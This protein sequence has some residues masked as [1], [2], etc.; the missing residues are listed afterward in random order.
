MKRNSALLTI[1]AGFLLL[2]PVLAGA[3]SGSPILIRPSSQ[4]FDEAYK[5][6]GRPGPRINLTQAQAFQRLSGH[7]KLGDRAVVSGRGALTAGAFARRRDSFIAA[8]RK[9]SATLTPADA[10]TGSGD[11]N[12]IEPN[13]TVAQSVALPVNVAGTINPSGD[14]DFFAFQ[15]F[16]GQQIT[17]ESFA[18]RIPGSNLIADIVLMDSAGNL[19]DEEQG[20]GVNDPFIQLQAPSTDILIAGITDLDGLGGS[21]FVYLLSMQAGVDVQEVEPNNTPTSP[22]AVPALPVTVFG[23]ITSNTDADFYQFFGTAGETLIA[24]VDAAV[25]GSSLVSEINLT[26]PATGVVYFY[27]NHLDGDDPR[28]NIVLPYTGNYM[29]GL[30]ALGAATSGFY[31]LNLS[32]VPGAGAPTVTGVTVLGPKTMK[33]SGAGFSPSPIVSL[34]ALD[35][36]TVKVSK[37]LLKAHGK[38]A[39]GKVVTV[40]IGPDGRRSNPLIIQ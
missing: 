36:P 30:D 12:E 5:A 3:Q 27:N 4:V 22:N 6:V 29:I 7:T 28:F 34:N 17:V 37:G 19:L 10:G 39:A 33:V 40:S 13:D 35:R 11:I 8:A 15:A 16:A 2:A 24:D 21:S 18:S 26:D 9:A 25:L 23:N 20:D 32:L 31:R 1:L 14:Q 38:G